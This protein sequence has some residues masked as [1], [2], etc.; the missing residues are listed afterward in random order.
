[1][2]VISLDAQPDGQNSDLSLFII[3]ITNHVSTLPQ[4]PHLLTT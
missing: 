4:A 3:V 2:L 1:M